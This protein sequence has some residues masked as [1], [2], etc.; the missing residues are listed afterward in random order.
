MGF[1]SHH[2]PFQDHYDPSGDTEWR[3]GKKARTDLVKSENW[4]ENLNFG[5]RYIIEDVK[6]NLAL[7]TSI[8]RWCGVPTPIAA[9]LLTLIG[10]LATEDF[11]LTGRT[12]NNL[13]V[14]DLSPQAMSD[15]LWNGFEA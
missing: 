4:R 6:C 11:N 1:T 12:L 2:Y 8:G 9:S 10:V 3:Y 5:H 14:G 15:L 13:G 7:I